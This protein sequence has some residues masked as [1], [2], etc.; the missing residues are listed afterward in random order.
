MAGGRGAEASQWGNEPGGG[1]K[2]GGQLDGETAP[3]CVVVSRSITKRKRRR[4]RQLQPLLATMSSHGRHER[5]VQN[6]KTPSA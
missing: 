2:E 5:H 6:N 4:R 1:V 3:G